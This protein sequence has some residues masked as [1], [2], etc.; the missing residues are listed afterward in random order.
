MIGL[1]PMV[2]RYLQMNERKLN[3]N[4]SHISAYPGPVEG[5][6]ERSPDEVKRNPGRFLSTRTI[7][8]YASLHPGYTLKGRGWNLGTSI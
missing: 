2:T 7:P 3:G 6:Q 5:L 8:D 4:S 1:F